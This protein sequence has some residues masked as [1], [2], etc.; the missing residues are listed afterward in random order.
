MDENKIF[1]NNQEGS[2]ESTEESRESSEG[3]IHSLQDMINEALNEKI[4]T[5]SSATVSISHIDSGILN[6]D[7]IPDQESFIKNL[8]QNQT[9]FAI[10]NLYSKFKN[11]DT[12]LT[13]V[14]EVILTREDLRSD[15]G[16]KRVTTLGYH[17]ICNPCFKNASVI[18]DS[19]ASSSDSSS[20]L[21]SI[22]PIST[23]STDILSI[24]QFHGKSYYSLPSNKVC[25]KDDIKVKN[26]IYYLIL[27]FSD[28]NWITSVYHYWNQIL[29]LQL[30]Q[31]KKL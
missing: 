12:R 7:Y 27:I 6:Q 16:N 9:N 4:D 25:R 10:E 23:R 21:A 29:N 20:H 3:S 11:L 22:D 8:E 13:R 15:T 5:S 2:R 28:R 1:I 31:C 26:S 17:N 24:D 18:L 14:E 19:T 30:N